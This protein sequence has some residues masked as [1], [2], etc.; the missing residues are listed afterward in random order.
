MDVKY[1]QTL[2]VWDCGKETK[3]SIDLIMYS[4]VCMREKRIRQEPWNW[5]T[6]IESKGENLIRV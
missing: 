2:K 1:K 3:Y 6:G 4:G 5:S